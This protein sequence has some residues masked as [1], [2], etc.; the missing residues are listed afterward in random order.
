MFSNGFLGFNKLVPNLH[1]SLLHHKYDEMQTRIS[2][3]LIH[4]SMFLHYF[5]RGA[6]FHGFCPVREVSWRFFNRKAL[7]FCLK[8]FSARFAFLQCSSMGIFFQ[9]LGQKCFSS[10]PQILCRIGQTGNPSW[11]GSSWSE[12]TGGFCAASKDFGLSSTVLENK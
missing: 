3:L 2:A 10:I 12:Y 1:C 6:L 9:N 7:S 8:V 4:A 11:L 5:S